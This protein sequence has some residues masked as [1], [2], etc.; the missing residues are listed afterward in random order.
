MNIIQAL[1]SS[2]P[3]ERVAN[4]IKPMIQK[5]ILKQHCLDREAILIW[6]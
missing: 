1:V 3:V 5:Q 2:S 6:Y 4:F